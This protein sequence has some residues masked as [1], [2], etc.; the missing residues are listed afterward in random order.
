[1]FNLLHLLPS[2]NLY[3]KRTGNRQS[4]DAPHIPGAYKVW[5]H[6]TYHEHQGEALVLFTDDHTM[7]AKPECDRHVLTSCYC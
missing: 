7:R 6:P 3:V 5:L 4:N 2:E 1:V